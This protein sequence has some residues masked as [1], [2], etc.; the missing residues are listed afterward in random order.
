MIGN[1]LQNLMEY[2]GDNQFT[3]VVKALKFVQEQFDR[4]LI[5]MQRISVPTPKQKG[6]N[7]Q[8][9]KILIASPSIVRRGSTRI[10]TIID[11]LGDKLNVQIKK[12]PSQSPSIFKRGDDSNRNRLSRQMNDNFSG[13]GERSEETSS[14]HDTNARITQFR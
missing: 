7:Q 14:Q 2:Q 12:Q 1:D 8:L 11:A 6:A 4:V 10:G 5:Q 13:R 9:E 3:K